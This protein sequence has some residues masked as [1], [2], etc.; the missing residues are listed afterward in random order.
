[1]A[2]SHKDVTFRKYTPEQAQAYAAGRGRGY[3]AALLQVIF[4]HHS[5]TGGEFNTLADIGCG[6]GNATCDLALDFD[7][8]FGLDP[9]SEMINAARSKNYKTKSGEDVVFRVAGAEEISTVGGLE[10]ASIDMITAATSVGKLL[11]SK[12]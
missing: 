8:A 11:V 7:H 4:Q 10:P 12:D 2:T 1:M 9:G 5:D 6:P 3:G